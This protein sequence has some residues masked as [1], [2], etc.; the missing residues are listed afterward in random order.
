MTQLRSALLADLLAP[1]DGWL[2]TTL[3]E[4]VEVT[5]GRQ[6]S[7]AHASG[8]HMVRYLRAANVKDGRLVLANVLTMN[9]SPLEQERVRSAQWR[10]LGDR[11]LREHPRTWRISCLGGAPHRHRVLSEHAATSSGPGRLDSCRFRRAVGTKRICHWTVRFGC[12]RDE[13]LPH[14]PKASSGDANVVAASRRAGAFGRSHERRRPA[15]SC[16]RCSVQASR[17]HARDPSG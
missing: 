12:V 7:P 1:R 6:R 16:P 17:A 5:I 2:E 3:G 15:G 11:R 14:R 10:C 13:Y 4:A 9:F 8:D